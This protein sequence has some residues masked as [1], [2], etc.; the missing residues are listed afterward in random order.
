MKKETFSSLD[1][2][3]NLLDEISAHINQEKTEKLLDEADEI[4][5]ELPLPDRTGEELDENKVK[6]MEKEVATLKAQLDH[7]E[8][9]IISNSDLRSAY[10]KSFS[11]TEITNLTENPLQA[12]SDWDP[13]NYDIVKQHAELL[14]NEKLQ[15]IMKL[16]EQFDEVV[17]SHSNYFKSS[18]LREIDS[19]IEQIF[20]SAVPTIK[21]MKLIICLLYNVL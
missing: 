3:V 5:S 4:V 15:P 6:L 1:E 11:N 18:Q 21:K 10:Q 14:M 17:N 20:A 8:K 9:I 2:P 19:Y 16:L 12:L 13:N 7:M